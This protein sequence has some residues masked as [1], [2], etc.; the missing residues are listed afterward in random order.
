MA[1]LSP[2]AKQQFFT[3]A[4]IP[5]AGCKLYTYAGGGAFTTPQA[6][7]TDAAGSVPNTN[8]II[9]DARGEAVVYLAPGQNYDY[10]LTDA[11]G[12]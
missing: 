3:D 1:S 8:P 6:T 10:K 11:A 9:L 5:A 7:Y 12:T 2:N 4:G